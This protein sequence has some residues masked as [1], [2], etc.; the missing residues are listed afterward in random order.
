[1]NE[2]EMDK[3]L[4]QTL[5]QRFSLPK[6]VEDALWLEFVRRRAQEKMAWAG[7]A[8]ALVRAG[9]KLQATVRRP[10]WPTDLAAGLAWR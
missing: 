1:M 3:L 4:A 2:R 10:A 6:G 5:G 8:A 9:A 7:F